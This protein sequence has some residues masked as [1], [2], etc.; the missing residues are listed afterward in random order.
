MNSLRMLFLQ[1]N[2]I[3]DLAPILE[4]ARKDAVK[5]R[6]YAPYLRLWLKGNP[7][8]SDAPQVRDLSKVVREVNFSYE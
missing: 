8:T 6:R 5:T 7:I 4:T 1:G 2:R 3:E